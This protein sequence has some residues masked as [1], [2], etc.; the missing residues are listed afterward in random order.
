MTRG[1]GNAWSHSRLT[2]LPEHPDI[3]VKIFVDYSLTVEA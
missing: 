2:G 1:T 3:K